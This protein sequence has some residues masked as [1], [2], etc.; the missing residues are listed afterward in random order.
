MCPRPPKKYGG[1][2]DPGNFI[3]FAK[4]YP[5]KAYLN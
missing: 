5:E 2:E 1:I 4:N 3:S